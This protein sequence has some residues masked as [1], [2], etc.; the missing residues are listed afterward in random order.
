MS[1]GA[2]PWHAHVRLFGP[3]RAAYVLPFVLPCTMEGPC[4]HL[5]AA[6]YSPQTKTAWE[7]PPGGGGRP[8][9]NR[10]ARHSYKRAAAASRHST[11][12]QTEYKAR[13]YAHAQWECPM[14]IWPFAYWNLHVPIFSASDER[15]LSHEGAYHMYRRPPSLTS[16]GPGDIGPSVLI[17]QEDPPGVLHLEATSGAV[18]NIVLLVHTAQRQAHM[19]AG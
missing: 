13:H 6:R 18:W 19:H 16:T 11:V 8:A 7:A 12:D 14:S 15:A 3:I 1:P 2:S 5:R 17:T 10:M 9:L 4:C